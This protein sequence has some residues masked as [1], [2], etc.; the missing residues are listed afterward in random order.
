MS[1]R[2]KTGLLA[3]LNDR[4]RVVDDPLQWILQVR[5]RQETGKVT[6]WVGSAYCVTRE[7]LLR[8]IGERCGPINPEALAVL[9]TLP[10]LH[11]APPLTREGGTHG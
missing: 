8:A 2:A 7:A 1:A 4:W 10:D 5:Q 9:Q 3:A 11:P 6:G